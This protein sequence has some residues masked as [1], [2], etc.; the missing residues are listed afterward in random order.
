MEDGSSWYNMAPL[1]CK[2]G[3]S[4]NLPAADFP[5]FAGYTFQGWALSDGGKVKYK[6]GASVK[7]LAE[8]D[9]KISLYAVWKPNKYTIVYK[10]N[11]ASNTTMENTSATY[12]KTVRLAKNTFK[13][14]GYTFKG[15]SLGDPKADV[16]YKD[17]KSYKNIVTSGKAVL[18]AQW[19]YKVKYVAN[20]D[21]ATTGILEDAMLKGH[22]NILINDPAFGQTKGYFAGWNTKADGSGTSYEGGQVIDLQPD[23]SGVVTLYAQWDYGQLYWPVRKDGVSITSLSSHH[24]VNGH[25]GIDVADA[26]GASYYAAFDGTISFVF[27]GCIANMN[28]DHSKCNPSH[29]ELKSEST[30]YTCNN[31]FGNGIVIRCEIEGQIYQIQY[32]HM[33]SVSKDLHE[34]DFVKRGTYL[35][36]VG[37]TGF[38]DGTH[39]HFE[40][41][42]ETNP[43]S[44]TAYWGTAVDNDYTHDGCVFTYQYD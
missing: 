38:S 30:N 37:D 4:Y 39:A 28:G 11:G 27:D 31:G 17:A 20:N 21:T 42:L 2:R 15:W 18:Y 1:I 13:L 23:S 24:G 5:A 25:R 32:A 36:E 41:D 40:I 9:K 14:S 12:G 3:K 22:D 35:G 16:L 6:D 44:S 10:G 7:D 29:P 43:G 8:A 26:V 33:A 34:G 19:G